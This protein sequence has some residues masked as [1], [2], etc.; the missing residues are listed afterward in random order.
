VIR[1]LKIGD[2]TLKNVVGSIT[3]SA[4]DL[5]LGQSFLNPFKSWSID[6]QRRAL[7]LNVLMAAGA[8]QDQS[9]H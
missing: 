5:L 1:S 4:S 7:I 3:P 2:K 6:N 9:A 8:D